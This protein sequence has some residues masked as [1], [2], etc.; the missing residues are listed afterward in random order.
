MRRSSITWRSVPALDALPGLPVPAVLVGLVILV[1]TP[2]ARA[3]PAWASAPD[4]ASDEGHVFACEGRGKT[5]ADALTAAQAVCND[6][7]CKVCGVELES[8]VETKETLQG[9]DVQRKVIER[10]RRVRKDET[11]PRYKSVECGPE[12]CVAWLQVLYSRATERAECPGYLSENFDDPAAC[13]KDLD[14]WKRVTG[15]TAASLRERVRLLELA[16]QHC[17]KIDVRPTP[18]LMAL[19]EKLRVGLTGFQAEPPK[20]RDFQRA[21]WAWYLVRNAALEQS[22]KEAKLFT[23][24]LRF[25]RDYCA[26]RALVFDVIEAAQAGDWDSKAGLE[27]LLAAMKKAP[28]RGQYDTPTV[29]FAVLFTLSRAKNDTSA[30]GAFLREQY[31]AA[32]L[33]WPEA[34]ELAKLFAGNDH[35][36]EAEWAFTVKAHEANKCAPCLRVLIEARQHDGAPDTRVKR[37]NQGLALLPSPKDERSRVRTLMELLPLG[38]AQFAVDVEK[39]LPAE[40]Q[41]AYGWTL[42]EEL[43]DRLGYPPVPP[44]AAPLVR[45]A[46]AGMVAEPLTE[47]LCKTLEQRLPRLMKFRAEPVLLD[48]LACACLDGPLATMPVRDQGKRELYQRALERGLACVR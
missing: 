12:G 32:E 7:I 16:L 36:T 34:F 10:C 17:A 47:T 9:I 15:R 28:R 5:E 11:P 38:D 3:A 8:V 37:L 40:F 21:T 44:Q 19:D 18:A 35:C 45:R 48:E 26:N 14:D 23:D 29:H 25:A 46:L 42:F 27:R 1:A 2:A 39:R 43:I 31:P 6:K 4:R 41:S 30:I 33:T 22:I 24:R 20:D 13:E